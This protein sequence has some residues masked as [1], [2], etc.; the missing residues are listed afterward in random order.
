MVTYHQRD[1]GAGQTGEPAY[2]K[3]SVPYEVYLGGCLSQEGAREGTRILYVADIKATVQVKILR[4]RLASIFFVTFIAHVHIH[5][6]VDVCMPLGVSQTAR[7]LGP[8]FLHGVLE[9][10]LSYQVWQQAP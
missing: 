6:C 3:L 10:K 9:T 8:F 5:M 4:S 7:G 1:Q 2:L